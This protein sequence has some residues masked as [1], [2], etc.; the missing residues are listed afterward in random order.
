MPF[1]SIDT[2]AIL[3]RPAPAAHELS[4]R[5][6]M[7]DGGWIE[8]PAEAGIRVVDL[9]AR[10][11]LPM[12]DT[13]RGRCTCVTCR[14]KIPPAWRNR[15]APPRADEASLLSDLGRDDGDNGTRLLCGLVM[16]PDLDGL[17]LELHWDALVPQTYW[18]AG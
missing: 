13:C 7:P 2:N 14:A 10:F 3:V 11:G 12:R 9:L 6:R 5:V 15:L 1:D 8:P 4:L 16:T 17:E 18:I